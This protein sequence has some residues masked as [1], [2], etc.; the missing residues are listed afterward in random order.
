[1]NRLRCAS[2]QFYEEAPIERHEQLIG[3]AYIAA[4]TSHIRSVSLAVSCFLLL[5]AVASAVGEGSVAVHFMHRYRA[6]L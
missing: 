6:S 5:L 4:K 1:M 2:G 3:M